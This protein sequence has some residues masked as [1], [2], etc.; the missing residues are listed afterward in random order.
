VLPLQADWE[1]QLRSLGW[2]EFFVKDYVKSLKTSRGSIVRDPSDICAVV[3]EMEQFR[4][5]I[6]GACASGGLSR[7]SRSRSGGT[8][9]WTG[10]RFRQTE[11]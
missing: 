7:S 8:S 10:R 9:C 5:E 4:G 1:A 2:N 11:A 3:A 6:E